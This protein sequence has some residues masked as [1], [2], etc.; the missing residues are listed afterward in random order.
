M[1]K[2]KKI[3]EFWFVVDAS[4]KFTCEEPEGWDKMTREQ[5]IE[6]VEIN[7]ECEGSLCHQCTDSIQSDFQ[8]IDE[9]MTRAL[10]EDY[11]P[12]EKGEEK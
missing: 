6:Y 7:A 8:V 4:A 11:F 1:K 2:N 12:E 9:Y 10:K 3:M 5:K